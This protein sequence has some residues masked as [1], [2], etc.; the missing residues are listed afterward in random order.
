MGRIMGIIVGILQENF[1]LIRVNLFF[2]GW[3]YFFFFNC[4][5]VDMFDF[6]KEGDFGLGVFVIEKNGKLK[7]LGIVFVVMDLCMV[8]CRIDIIVDE[9]KLMVVRYIENKSEQLLFVMI[10]KIMES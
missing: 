5:V 7:F 10:R 4:Y 3:G 2:L 9:L 8:V 6:F 1:F